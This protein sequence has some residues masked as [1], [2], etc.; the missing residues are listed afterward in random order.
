[1]VLYGR[2]EESTPGQKLSKMLL[3][4]LSLNSETHSRHPK[5]L[6]GIWNNLRP[7]VDQ[8]VL[9][10]DLQPPLSEEELEHGWT[11]VP[12]CPVEP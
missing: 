2:S 4:L 5:T 6:Y 7:R 3:T 11:V 12:G 8:S 10:V 1:M 9:N